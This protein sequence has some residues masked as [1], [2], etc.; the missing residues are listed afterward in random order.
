MDGIE[1]VRIDSS[2]RDSLKI[3]GKF[4]VKVEKDIKNR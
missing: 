2:L 1:E 3:N 4:F